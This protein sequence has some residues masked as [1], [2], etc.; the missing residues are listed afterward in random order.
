MRQPPIILTDIEGT[1]SSISFVK[2]VLF[3]YAAKHLPEFVRQHANDA[4][5]QVQLQTLADEL[6]VSVDEMDVLIATLLQYIKEDRK[7]TVLK[8]LQ[9]MIWLRG[10]RDG[11]YTAHVYPDAVQQLKQWHTQGIPIHVYSSGSI[12]A[13][14]LFFQYSDFGDLRYLFN[15]YFDTT[16]GGKRETQSYRNILNDLNVEATRVWFFSDIIEELDAAHQAGLHTVLLDR[17]EDY[18]TPRPKPKAHQ[19]VTTFKDI[20]FE[21]GAREEMRCL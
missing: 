12:A 6:Q 17:I 13:Q 9:G 5:V 11:D 10:Y 3:P 2:D 4:K 19:R 1:T 20:I 18:P 14:K 16:S 15:G 7:H 21:G 8:T